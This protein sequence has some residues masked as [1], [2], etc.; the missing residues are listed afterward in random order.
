MNQNWQCSKINPDIYLNFSL[1]LASGIMPVMCT[2]SNTCFIYVCI[3]QFSSVT[4]SFLTLCNP[5]D[6]STA[7]HP[8]HHQLPELVRLISI[9]LVM[10]SNHLI[11][12]HPLLL[13]PSIVPSIRVFPTSQFSSGGQIIG[14]ST[15]ASVLQMD[16]QDWFPLGWTGFITLLF[17]G[18]SRVFF[19]T[20]VQKHHFFGAQLSLWSNSHIHT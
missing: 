12:C 6:C 18:L 8:V 3:H 5:M 10:S 20:T 1:Y 19:N 13:L 7:G 9:E 16:I 17:K 2:K 4:Q 11:L 14:V 15:P